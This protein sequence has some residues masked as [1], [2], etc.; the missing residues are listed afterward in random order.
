MESRH[1]GAV[2]VADAYGKLV[3][4]VGDVAAPVFPRSAVKAM[5]ALALVESG[6]ADRYGLERRGAGARLRS[7]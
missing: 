7:P 5:Q 6:V 2:A 3:L 1:R 4:S